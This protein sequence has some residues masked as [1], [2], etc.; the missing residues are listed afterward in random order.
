MTTPTVAPSIART[1]QDLVKSGVVRIVS[2]QNDFFVSGHSA[3]AEADI[4]EF[5]RGLIQYDEEDKKFYWR[6]LDGYSASAPQGAMI[7]WRWLEDGRVAIYGDADWRSIFEGDPRHSTFK[8]KVGA[9]FAWVPCIQEALE[10][11]SG[12]CAN[13]FVEEG[14]WV[15]QQ[16]WGLEE[17]GPDDHLLVLKV[18][19]APDCFIWALVSHPGDELEQAIT[20]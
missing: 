3:Y 4:P 16:P 20:Y 2:V 9:Q 18:L 17:I 11:L 14:S 5:L 19:E 1:I 6:T 15:I 8:L 10:V 7:L 13:I 12:T